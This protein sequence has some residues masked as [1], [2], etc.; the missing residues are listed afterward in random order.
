MIKY[1][2]NINYLNILSTIM[3]N[4]NRL[5]YLIIYVLFYNLKMLL[6]VIILILLLLLLF[7]FITTCFTGSYRKLKGGNSRAEWLILRLGSAPL[8]HSNESDD[9]SIDKDKANLSVA[10]HYSIKEKTYEDITQLYINA[11][12]DHTLAKEAYVRSLNGTGIPLNHIYH[13]SYLGI[14]DDDVLG[15]PA[16][17]NSPEFHADVTRFLNGRKFKFIIT[18]YVTTRWIDFDVSILASMYLDDDGAFILTDNRPPTRINRTEYVL[19]K[20]LLKD[21][22]KKY[23]ESASYEL[24]STISDDL[25]QYRKKLNSIFGGGGTFYSIILTLY[26]IGNTPPSNR[27]PIYVLPHR[28]DEKII[29]IIEVLGAI[30]VMNKSYPIEDIIERLK[31]MEETALLKKT[32]ITDLMHDLE[33]LKNEAK[34]ELLLPRLKAIN[35]FN[36]SRILEE[37]KIFEELEK[38]RNPIQG[39]TKEQKEMEINAIWNQLYRDKNKFSTS[40]QNLIGNRKRV[41]EEPDQSNT[42]LNSTVWVLHRL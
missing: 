26:I 31:M 3:R 15:T 25:S 34:R 16:L 42:I 14:Y 41:F 9:A 27:F 28:I 1:F 7:Y 10:H 30:R 11:D 21:V 29:F 33:A 38:L 22:I 35:K 17:W 37:L 13:S 19:D 36:Q 24:L 4:I 23:E 40:T 12:A 6:L 5:K 8:G 32:R 18:D 2:E 39:M 20:Q